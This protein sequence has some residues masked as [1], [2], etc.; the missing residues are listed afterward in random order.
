MRR[1]RRL[2]LTAAI[3]TLSMLGTTSAAYAYWTSTGGGSTTAATATAQAMAVTGGTPAG[4]LYPGGQ[5]D[6]ALSVSNPNPFPAR[7][8]SLSLNTG[9]GTGGFALDGGH[10]GCGLSAL[11]FAPQT[12]GGRGW[13]IPPK[14]GSTNGSLAIGLANAIAM[15][16]NAA[17]ACQGATFTV[18][19]TASP[20]YETTILGTTGLVGYW[21]LGSAPVAVDDFTDSAGTS[22]Q[23]H[24][25]RTAA[26]WT[27]A[28]G[29]DAVVTDANRLRRSGSGH[30]L[31]YASAIA[32]SADYA[33]QAEVVPQSIIAGDAIGVAGRIDPATGDHYAAR[34][35]TA[36]SSWNLLRYSGGTGTKLASVTG[37]PLTIGQ[38]YRMRLG[39]RGN[40]ITLHVDGVATLTA[41]DST[42][43][44][45]GKAGVRLGIEGGNVPVTNTTGLQ[46]DNFQ[47]VP[48]TGNTVRDASAS[49]NVG[50]LLGS[51]VLGEP[52]A[53]A[54]DYNTATRWDGSTS[55]ASIPDA[56]SLDLGD[57]P[58]TLEA[59]VKRADTAATK[60]TIINK[61][62]GSYQLGFEANRLTLYANGVQTVAQATTGPLDTTSFHHYVA[63]K[64]GSSV[65][66]Y[67]DGVDVTGTVTNATLGNTTSPLRLGSADG[68]SQFLNG[69]QEEVAVYNVALD[70]TT[71]RN[72]YHL[73]HGS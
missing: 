43:S 17:T 28:G 45:A 12:N 27:R 65:R 56:N 50:S 49:A 20:D 66:L 21:R 5:A 11:T 53:L 6:V 62:P 25:G 58:F 42:Y 36:D 44:A 19:L 15:D 29:L 72:H 35:D 63:S 73:G 51:P 4:A 26:N 57:G 31:Y 47:V 68:S 32:A 13:Y 33:V 37:Q 59:W 38:S 8:G 34:Y 2:R 18:Y 23:A 22:L 46:L 52:G 40:T 9:Q 71:A 7:I 48:D 41:T 55:Y 70:A 30:S 64:D 24:T 16:T 10:V 14:V 54:G 67:V 61:G 3:A 1:P 69:T 39:L 60:Q